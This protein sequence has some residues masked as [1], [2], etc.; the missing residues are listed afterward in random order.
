MSLSDSKPIPMTSQEEKEIHRVFELLCDY[1]EKAKVRQEQSDIEQ[2]VAAHRSRSFHDAVSEASLVTTLNRL[3]EVKLQL[4]LIEQRP[5]KRISAGDVMEMM[6]WLKQKASRKEVEE[7]V[8]EVDENLDG[9]LDWAEFRLMFNRNIMDRSGL[10]PSRMYNLTQFLIYDKNNNGFVSV[11]ETMNLLYARFGRSVME[12]KLKELFG[13]DMH[14][15]GLEGGEIPFHRYLTAVERVQLNMF[16]ETNRGKKA[17]ELQHQQH[18][19]R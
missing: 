5:D 18:R 4:Q 12:Q 1:Q 19:K 16:L 11:D 15:F 8:W 2:W 13:E 17:K 3:E 10:E 6:K 9:F 14:E 7:M